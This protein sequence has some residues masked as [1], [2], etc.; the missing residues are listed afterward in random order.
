MRIWHYLLENILSAKRSFL[1]YT[2]VNSC[3]V[4]YYSHSI[5]EVDLLYQH[6]HSGHFYKWAKTWIFKSTVFWIIWSR[7]N[8]LV[9]LSI[10]YTKFSKFMLFSIYNYCLKK[11][12]R[13]ASYV[14]FHPCSK[15]IPQSSTTVIKFLK[16]QNVVTFKRVLRF[17][18]N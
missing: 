18:K 10:N 8:V 14:T 3:F 12:I 11:V 4:N 6:L 13:V 9:V 16:T 2:N 15:K 7:N 17:P 1:N 5:T